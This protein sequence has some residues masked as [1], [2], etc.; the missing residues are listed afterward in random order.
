MNVSGKTQDDG[1]A[2]D[3]VRRTVSVDEAARWLGVSRAAA[4]AA[5]ARGE[6]PTL[7]IGRRVLVPR[8]Q[9]AA[10]LGEPTKDRP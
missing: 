7:R 1:R 10:M 6:I 3:S 9:L 5:V 8:A 4:Y 2:R